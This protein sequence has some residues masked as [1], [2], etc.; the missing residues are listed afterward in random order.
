MFCQIKRVSVIH[1]YVNLVVL[2]PFPHLS[3]PLSLSIFP[4]QLAHFRQRKT[5]S[6]NTQ[7]QKKAA[8]RKGSSDHTSDIPKEEGMLAAQDSVVFT[9][10][11]I[12]MD[13]KTDETDL[14]ETRFESKVSKVTVFHL[15]LS[16]T[17]RFF[18]EI[19][20]M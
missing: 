20:Y 8:K 3:L 17:N 15:N 12:T 14:S 1:E 19:L 2:L 7:S 16:V 5:K 11:S 10:L 9:D 4:A 13:S 6:D 18:F